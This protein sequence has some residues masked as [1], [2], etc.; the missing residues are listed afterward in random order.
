MPKKKR[1][2]PIV[3]LSNPTGKGTPGKYSY[4]LRVIPL[5]DIVPSPFQRRRDFDPV[6]LKELAESIPRTA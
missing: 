6:K 1:R 3:L 2:K 5:K 4:T